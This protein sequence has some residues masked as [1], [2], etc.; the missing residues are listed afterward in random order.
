MASSIVIAS[1]FW[2]DLSNNVPAKARLLAAISS[3]I[4][5]VLLTGNYVFRV[6]IVWVDQVLA[7]YPLLAQLLTVLGLATL[8]NGFNM[9]DGLNGFA[10]GLALFCCFGLFVIGVDQE[11]VAIV[12]ASSILMASILGFY[13][14]N[15]PLGQIFLG[16]GGAYGLGIILGALC[17]EVLRNPNVSPIFCLVLVWYPLV[18]T[19]FSFV[20]KSITPRAN[21]FEPD[22]NHLHILVYQVL[23]SRCPKELKDHAALNPLASIILLL[24]L[25]PLTLAPILYYNDSLSLLLTFVGNCFVYLSAWFYLDRLKRQSV[26]IR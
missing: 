21:P 13:F 12:H 23:R 26:M 5:F 14:F 2:E 25:M 22:D 16:D 17:I 24:V 1:G 3:S 10:S 15:F 20:R 9:V 18:E 4:L 7:G 19:I 11:M 8:I 6:E